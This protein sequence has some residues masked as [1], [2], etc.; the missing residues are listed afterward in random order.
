MRLFQKQLNDCM[1]ETNEK[2]T[3]SY[4]TVNNEKN[5]MTN[6]LTGVILLI[7]LYFYSVKC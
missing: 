1:F 3:R 4:R 2:I 7:Q 6:K 5:N